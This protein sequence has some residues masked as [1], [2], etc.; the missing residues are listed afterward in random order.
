[1][2]GNYV[3]S[4]T[5]GT[6]TGGSIHVGDFETKEL[7]ETAMLEHYR[8][9]PKRGNFYYQINKE[10]LEEIQG[11]TYR[12]IGFFGTDSYLKR[13]TAAELKQLTA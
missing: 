8:K 1:M 7:A 13:Y 6:K 11:I 3:F 9:T 12:M 2:N 10:K 4:V 5:R